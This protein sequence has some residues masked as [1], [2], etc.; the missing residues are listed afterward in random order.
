MKDELVSMHKNEVLDLVKFLT[1]CKPVGCKWIFK[2]KRNAQGNIKKYKAKLVAKGFTQREG[3]DYIE[4]FSPVLTK[5][6]F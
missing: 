4:T 6:S 2:A 1:S 3:I 5:D